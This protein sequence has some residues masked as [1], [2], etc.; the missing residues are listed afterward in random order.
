MSIFGKGSML[1][2]II[3]WVLGLVKGWIHSLNFIVISLAWKFLEE[4]G[5]VAVWISGGVVSFFP[6]VGVVIWAQER[7]KKQCSDYNKKTCSLI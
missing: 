7:I 6:P 4:L 1:G 2:E 3:T 5:G